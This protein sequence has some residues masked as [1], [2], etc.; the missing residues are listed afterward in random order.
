MRKAYPRPLERGV[1]A[2]A[3]AAIVG[4]AIAGTG[5]SYVS[6]RAR[7]FGDIFALGVSDGGGVVARIVPTRLLALEAGARKDE[8]FYG[9]RRGRFH[10]VE[11]SYG[12]PFAF[13][14]SSSLG[15]EGV[16][17]WEGS[18][19]IRTSDTMLIFPDF[20]SPHPRAVPREARE[21]HLFVLT[22][23]SGTPLVEE[24]DIQVDVSA[25]IAGIQI[26]LSPGQLV[27]FFAG[28]FTI[29]VAGDDERTG[30][31]GRGGGEVTGA[32]TESAAGP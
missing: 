32:P 10:W 11:S 4:A 1:A 16:R 31:W 30:P 27:D 3:A 8:T 20:E 19:V 21:Y 2:L 6:E 7:D 22:G 5:C 18:D 13:F 14:R 12:F 29:D 25:L 26:I 28:L 23:S 17:P 24:L 9:Y 15:G